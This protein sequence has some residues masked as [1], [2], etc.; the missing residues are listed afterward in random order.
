LH[1]RQP[2]WRSLFQ[3]LHRELL[4]GFFLGLG[5]GAVVA[6]TALVWLGNVRLMFCLLGG[7]TGGVAGAAGLGLA[8][9][10]LLRLLHLEPRV[11]AG[12]IALA[13]ADVITIV[14]YLNIARWLLA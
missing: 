5:A 6:L 13:G 3:G 11:A 4:T 1:G 8:L 14:L 10:V 7:I 9:P 2:T 12:P